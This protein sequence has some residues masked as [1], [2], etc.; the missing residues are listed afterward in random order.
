MERA[1]SASQRSIN[2]ARDENDARRRDNLIAYT[3]WSHPRH[4]AERT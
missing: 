4:A 3:S 1:P 2:Y